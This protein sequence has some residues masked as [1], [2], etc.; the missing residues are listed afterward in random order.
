MGVRGENL[1]DADIVG[2]SDSYTRLELDG[3]KVQT[4]VIEN[5]GSNPVW[6]EALTLP[7]SKE[8]AAVASVGGQ[9]PVLLVSVWDQDTGGDDAMGNG[10]IPLAQLFDQLEDVQQPGAVMRAYDLGNTKSGRIVLMLEWRPHGKA[11]SE[12]DLQAARD[13]FGQA[14]EGAGEYS[15]EFEASAGAAEA[16][17]VD[18]EDR[19]LEGVPVAHIISGHD[20]KDE[21]AAGSSDAFVRVTACGVDRQTRVIENGG[22]QPYWNEAV[23]LVVPK[24]AAALAEAKSADEVVVLS[25]WDQDVGSDDAMGSARVPLAHIFE[26]MED[27]RADGHA[28]RVYELQQGDKPAGKIVVVWE[29]KPFGKLGSDAAPASRFAEDAPA[30][31]EDEAAAAAAAAPAPAPESDVEPLEG[32]LTVHVLKGADLIDADIAGSSDSY[33]RI[34]LGDVVQKTEVIENG[35]NN[36]VWNETFVFNLKAGPATA[37]EK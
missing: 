10:A 8:V 22:A 2:S 13:A 19:H 6:D 11:A 34:K 4:R 32:A 25:V 24:E 30:T 33:V 17:P 15:D 37:A 18:E 12:A 3:H 27:V 14:A 36:P 16:Q 29:W 5:G 35:G 20:L 21:D 7:V 9:D 26:A 31:A 28:R 1:V 23:E